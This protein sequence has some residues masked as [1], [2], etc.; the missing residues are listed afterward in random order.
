MIGS[1]E[2]VKQGKPLNLD[3]SGADGPQSDE[4]LPPVEKIDSCAR[5]ILVVQNKW[6]KGVAI[7]GIG[8]KLKKY[9]C[10]QKFVRVAPFIENYNADYSY[11]PEPNFDSADEEAMM[12]VDVTKDELIFEDK[13]LGLFGG[14]MNTLTF[15]IKHND[16]NWLLLSAYKD[17]LLQDWRSRDPVIK[18]SKPPWY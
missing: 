14:T 13:I 6:M 16:G 7:Y 8:Q 10:N 2:G 18:Y 9:D 3:A 5:E 17:I 1:V 11:V 15:D 4:E 12:L